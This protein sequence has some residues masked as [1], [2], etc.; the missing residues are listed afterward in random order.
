MKTTWCLSASLPGLKLKICLSFYTFLL[1]HQTIVFNRATRNQYRIH[2]RPKT[3]RTR[4][5]PLK[6]YC[7]KGSNQIVSQIS[8]LSYK[9]VSSDPSLP[10]LCSRSKAAIFRSLL[11]SD[12]WYDISP[13]SSSACR[14][15]APRS[16]N[17]F[18]IPRY[19]C[20]ADR[21][22]GIQWFCHLSFT[23]F[24]IEEHP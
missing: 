9:W 15:F 5:V 21:Y 3:I 13:A 17:D 19:P 11:R 10:V 24:I 23:L 16:S 12:S 6:P 22:S 8:H 18:T 2:S 20:R 1:D 4:V 14:T 7:L